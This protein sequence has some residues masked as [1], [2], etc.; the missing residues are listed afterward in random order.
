MK[1]TI[2]LLPQ[3]NP[4]E[5]QARKRKR[6]TYVFIAVSIFVLFLVW[7]VPFLILQNLKREEQTL[8]SEVSAKE[9]SLVRL[10]QQEQLYRTV[11]YKSLASEIVLKS[12]EKLLKDIRNVKEFVAPE[13]TLSSIQI[14]IDDVKMGV[15]TL[16][17]AATMAYLTDLEDENKAKIFKTLTITSIV[18]EKSSG[19][20][21]GIQGQLSHEQ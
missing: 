15:T 21:V 16:D 12:K 18:V 20:K 19:Y 9:Q 17:L 3:K 13:L 10:S 2:N 1:H 14:N 7:L 11:F 6:V 8:V 4:F 5:E